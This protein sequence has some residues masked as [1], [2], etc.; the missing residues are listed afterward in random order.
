MPSAPFG[1]DSKTALKTMKSVLKN[2][3]EQWKPGMEVLL[4]FQSSSKI[5][6]S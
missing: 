4:A 3:V 1:C 5:G 2:A 6:K